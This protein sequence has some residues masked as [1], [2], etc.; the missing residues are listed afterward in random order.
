M[1]D[2]FDGYGS[3]QTPRRTPSGAPAFDEMFG[4]VTASGA[5]SQSREAYRELQKG[6]AEVH[7]GGRLG[8]YQYL[9]MHM[10]IGSALSLWN[11]TLA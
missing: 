4:D 8:T 2:L 11:N 7:F 5:P 10:A 3:T 9:D 6:E 1:G